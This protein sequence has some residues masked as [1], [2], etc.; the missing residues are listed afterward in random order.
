M[1][2]FSPTRRFVHLLKNLA[3]KAGSGGSAAAFAVKFTEQPIDRVN[4]QAATGHAHFP[5]N[6]VENGQQVV[7][8]PE[9]YGRA[10]R[11]LLWLLWG[12]GHTPILKIRPAAK[13]QLS[14]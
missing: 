8:Y 13:P 6:P 1:S 14:P 2:L 3:I 4:D 7:P 9:R 12:V 11:W 5:R 10:G